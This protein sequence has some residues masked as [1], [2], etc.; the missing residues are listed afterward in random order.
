[1]MLF[2]C[3]CNLRDHF[4]Y[5]WHSFKSSLDKLANNENIKK[6]QP[7]AVMFFAL[8]LSNAGT[9][10]AGES[11]KLN[12]NDSGKTVEIRI[13]DELEVVLPGNPTTGYGWEVISL[14]STVLSLDKSEFLGSDKAIGSGGMEIIKLHAIAEGKS[15]VKLIFHRAFEQNIPPLKTFD[16]TI[17]IKK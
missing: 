8:M 9:T 1:M 3:K 11:M 6:I 14:D 10:L 12:E 2:N 17:I 16:V 13:G 7:C 5:F 15:A 4:G